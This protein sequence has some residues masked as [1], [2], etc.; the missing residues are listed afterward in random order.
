MY[1]IYYGLI[2]DESKEEDGQVEIVAPLDEHGNLLP[3]LMKHVCLYCEHNVQQINTVPEDRLSGGRRGIQKEERDLSIAE[4]QKA[5]LTHEEKSIDEMMIH[6]ILKQGQSYKPVAILK[7]VQN[8][9]EVAQRVS[10]KKMK[11][12]FGNIKERKNL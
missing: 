11:S 10:M 7:F 6:T 2:V 5:I 3:A 9:W 1:A 12:M 4:M 8:S